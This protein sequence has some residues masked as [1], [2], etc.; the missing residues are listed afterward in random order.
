MK[1]GSIVPSHLDEGFNGDT[2]YQHE[3][4]V[5]V[6]AEDDRLRPIDLVKDPGGYLCERR[7]AD[8]QATVPS[9]ADTD[10]RTERQQLLIGGVAAPRR[11][12]GAADLA[13]PFGKAGWR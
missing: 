7:L 2:A 13:D 5:V 4:P 6:G 1:G 3:H 11:P 9:I 12:V 10:T 8:H